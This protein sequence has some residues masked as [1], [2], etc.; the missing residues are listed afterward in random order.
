MDIENNGVP[1]DAD[2][3][4]T[5]WNGPCGN[6]VKAGYIPANVDFAT[7]AGFASYIDNH[8]PYLA[9]VYSSGGTWYGSWEGIFGN[10]KLS[11]AAEWTFTN[12]QSQLDPPSGF[13]GSHASAQWFSSAAGR[14][15]SAV[16]VVRR[17]W[18]AQRLR[19][20]RSG[21]GGQRRQ[22]RLR[23]ARRRPAC[24]DHPS[25]LIDR[26]GRTACP[27]DPRVLPA[28]RGQ[29]LTASPSSAEPAYLTLAM[30]SSMAACTSAGR[31]M[32][33]ICPAPSTR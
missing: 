19:R 30:V 7:W 4:N 13:S 14:L 16:A 3:W 24:G 28:L 5:V 15:R 22:P 27:P 25:S 12:E 23:A 29:T 18:R 31:S 6:T 8:S 1:P 11:S 9:G 2:G 32:C 20:L 26:T 10:E 33:G 21:R 17:E